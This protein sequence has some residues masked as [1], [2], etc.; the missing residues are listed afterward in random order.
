[1]SKKQTKTVNYI[2]KHL[3]REGTAALER[4]TQMF[5]DYRG[6]ELPSTYVGISP[7]R[8]LALQGMQAGGQQYAPAF[9]EWQKTVSG[10]YLDPTTNPHFQ[11]IVQDSMGRAMGGV[12][13]QFSR[14][15]MGGASSLAGHM[16]AD[17]GASTAARLY[18]N[19]YDS[20]RGRMMGALQNAPMMD[21]LQY[22]DAMR[23]GQVGMEYERDLSGRAAEEMRQ[24]EYPIKLHQQELAAMTANPLMGESTQKTTQPFDWMG[25][26]GGI[27]GSLMP[28]PGSMFGGGGGG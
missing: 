9:D 8:E 4:G 28:S 2:N 16:G 3:R 12:A 26:V 10:H 11:R 15:G 24:F 6:S 25:L 13:G 18:G 20:E 17:V 14:Y 27:A 23:L 21:R 7:E 19:L 5:E 22:G 1:M